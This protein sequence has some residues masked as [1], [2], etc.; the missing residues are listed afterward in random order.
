MSFA[1][2][3]M[4]L[5]VAACWVGLSA[6]PALAADEVR[7]ANAGIGGQTSAE[8]LSRFDRD[9]IE[10]KPQHLVIYFGMN[11]ACNSRKLVPVDQYESNLQGMIDRAR[12]A[13]VQTIVLVTPNP[14]VD[15][16]LA[17]RH[18]SHPNEGRFQQWLDQYDAVVRKTA[19]ANDLPLADL[20]ALC[21]AHGGADIVEQS[22]I[23][24][25]VNANSDDGVHL[26]DDGYRLMAEMIAGILQDNIKP[27]DTVVCIGDSITY[28]SAMDGEGTAYGQTY[29][30]WLWLYLNQHLGATDRDTP[31]V[32]ENDAPDNLVLNGDFETSE[33]GVHPMYWRSYRMPDTMTSPAHHG[34]AAV[35]LHNRFTAPKMFTYIPPIDIRGGQTYRYRFAVRG[36]GTIRPMM[37]MTGNGVSELHPAADDESSWVEATDAWQEHGGEVVA[38]DGARRMS[39][40]FQVEAKGQVTLDAVS[41]T[42]AP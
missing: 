13:G 2:R 36:E 31:R 19:E 20:R 34:D 14:V 26:T 6:S 9:V 1:L 22:L 17:M 37:R 38:P 4:V 10:A 18:D 25:T 28:G 24:N 39:L 21:D 23:R 12:D 32:Y 16:Y 35:H 29:P 7:V 3:L 42:I 27:G 33:D 15:A 40:M 11:D 30:A 41:V 5:V 8:G